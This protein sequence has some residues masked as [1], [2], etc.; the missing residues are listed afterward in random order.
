M[1]EA[2][3]DLSSGPPRHILVTAFAPFG[4]PL[5]PNRGAN[6]SEEVARAW[7]GRG[8]TG[9]RVLVLPVSPAAEV[10][11]ARALS[12]NPS[13]I[14]ATGEAAFPPGPDTVLEPWAEDREVETGP[15]EGPALRLHSSAADEISLVDG[16]ARGPSIGR[17]WCNRV[18]F[19]ILEWTLVHPRPAVFLHMR[20]EG[21]RARQRGHL[22][23]VV[24]RLDA[25]AR[26]GD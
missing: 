8:R 18:Y 13:A 3:R 6:A 1:P 12:A 21:D 5:R 16:L 20:V 10:V 15:A 14:V 25:M 11:L 19:R 2:P 17:Y 7:I 4:T 24:A 22:D 23:H 26:T 9:V